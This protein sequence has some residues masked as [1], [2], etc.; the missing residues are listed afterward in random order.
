MKDENSAIT[1]E[2]H[3]DGRL[4]IMNYE[5]HETKTKNTLD[6]SFGAGF[7]AH[8]DIANCFGSIYTHSLEWAIQGY[9]EAKERLRD[10]KGEKH[11]SSETPNAMKLPAF[12]LAPAPLASRLK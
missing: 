3:N 6:I 5:D 8:A 4:F 2:Q 9:E 10:R 12:Q 11:W 1:A 7:R